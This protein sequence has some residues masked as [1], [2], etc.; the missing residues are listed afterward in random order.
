MHS[1][2]CGRFKCANHKNY[3]F[4]KVSYFLQKVRNSDKFLKSVNLRICDLRS[5]IVDCSVPTFD[6]IK[7]MGDNS[8]FTLCQ[9]VNRITELVTL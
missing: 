9:C 6:D 1:R 4:C 2:S 3:R 7:S 8:S 5:L